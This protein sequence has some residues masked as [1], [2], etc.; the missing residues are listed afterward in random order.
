MNHMDRT[1]RASTDAAT[2]ARSVP[3]GNRATPGSD[4][5]PRQRKPRRTV[6]AAS[7]W[8]ALL[9]VGAAL[10]GCDRPP[11]AAK[12][13]LDARVQPAAT[14][15]RSEGA[16]PMMRDR[17]LEQISPLDDAKVEALGSS[18]AEVARA[19]PRAAVELSLGSDA[20]AS[21]KAQRL[22]SS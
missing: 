17:L 4:A 8:I 6:Q 16:S 15:A 11:Q 22:V 5:Q 9:V 1:N 19:A 21:V 13:D 2:R 10:T 14:G 18:L 12:A 7:A 20:E 3:P